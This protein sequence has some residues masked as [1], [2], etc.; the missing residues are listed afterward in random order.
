MYYDILEKL[1]SLQ[2]FVAVGLLPALWG[3]L[4]LLRKLFYKVKGYKPAPKTQNSK[5]AIKF[6][7]LSLPC[8]IFCVL[9]MGIAVAIYCMWP[10]DIFM[11]SVS[12]YI[13]EFFTVV[14]VYGYLFGI[15]YLLYQAIYFVCACVLG[16]RYYASKKSWIIALVFIVLHIAM[17]FL[18][19]SVLGAMSV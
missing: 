9:M 3:G 12:N 8:E 17:G 15:F 2:V 14:G 11:G 4:L 16:Y 7:N 6:Y 18:Y 13:F 10:Y 19:I 5:V 1:F